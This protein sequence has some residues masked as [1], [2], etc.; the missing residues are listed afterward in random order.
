MEKVILL[1]MDGL[2]WNVI[3]DSLS[4]NKLRNLRRIIK[5]GGSS[6]L[7][8]DHPLI[9]PKIWTS[10]FTGKKP[11]KHGIIDFFSKR[12]DLNTLQLWEILHH[13][14]LKVGV[15]R[16][17]GTWDILEVNGFF[18]P[19]FL[20]FKKIA[21]PTKYTII[22]ELDQ[23]ARENKDQGLS[24]AYMVKLILKFL[25]LGFPIIALLKI[26]F[27]GLKL[28]LIRNQKKKLYIIKKIEFLIHSNFFLKLFK[29]YNPDF[30]F[31]YEN[32]CDSL[33]HH[34]WNDYEKK[35]KYKNTLP[36]TYLLIDK[37]IGKVDKLANKKGIN[38]IIISDHGF[39]EVGDLATSSG[40]IALKIPEILT[41]LELEN[42]L[43]GISLAKT[44]VFRLKLSSQ[45]NL[46]EAE[47]R[48]LS[49][50]N[51]GRKL[52]DTEIL[53]K[54]LIVRIN[55]FFGNKKNFTVNSFKGKTIDIESIIDF[56]SE[57][58]GAH[59]E[60]DGVF[61]AKGQS[62]RRDFKLEIVKPYDLTPTI[63]ALMNQ[64]IP[65]NVDG[66]VLEEIFK[67]VPD[68]KYYDEEQIILKDKKGLNDK[69]E[70]IIKDRLRSLGYL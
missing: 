25:K 64:A 21:H 70:E 68:I 9:S 10:I 33:S 35:T 36:K 40:I 56:E 60:I 7:N 8:A 38:L 65:S 5:E 30:A 63:L 6:N 69:E 16:A 19:S 57:N 66:R 61:I 45:I 27:N 22:S 54:Y 17:L 49:L 29:K 67:R 62:I 43:H 48:F 11:E 20:A 28:S 53:N 23:K 39:T 2:S 3:N 50:E 34:F 12:E 58:T 59:S 14:N 26:I 1:G 46:V 32:S 31:L 24:A 4:K 42:D 37:F 52:F 44:F 13:N 18:I 41:F 47:S 51:S 15:Y 55:N